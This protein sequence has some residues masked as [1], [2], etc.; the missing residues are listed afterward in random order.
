MYQWGT[1]D[2]INA[3]DDVVNKT[4]RHSAGETRVK[5][6]TWGEP[7]ARVGGGVEIRVLGTMK[8]VFYQAAAAIRSRLRSG[9]TM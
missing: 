1:M 3:F 8:A 2:I 9:V 6:Y 4:K 7:K 5:E